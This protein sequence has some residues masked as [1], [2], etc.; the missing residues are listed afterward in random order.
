MTDSQFLKVAKQAA[1]EAGKIIQK[2]SG[3]K[4]KLNFKNN[5]LSDFSTKADLEVEESIVEILTK[6][7]PDHNI[8]AEE[9]TRINK[10]SKYTWVIDPLDGTA[11]FV[12]D[13]PTFGVSIGLLR[14]NL[15]FLGVVNH[16]PFN[17]LYWAQQDKGAYLNGK[18]V[19]VT[20]VGKLEE[21]G[22]GLDFGHRKSRMKKVNRYV[23][24]IAGKVSYVYCFGSAVTTQAFV[25][26]GILDGYVA[27]AWIWDFAAGA[28]I[29]KEAGGKVTDF[30]G[31]EPDWTNN[32]LSLV[33]SNGLIHDQILEA[34]R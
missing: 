1:L 9:K 12:A 14:E 30:E 19:L 29:V 11:S 6:N 17:D 10:N 25:G 16:V 7:F 15:P 28:V 32:R 8:I 22:V 21:A 2:Y 23:V 27:E 13:V 31:K 24:P 26:K 4:S 18:R 3:K 5:D 33:L 20:R 34:L